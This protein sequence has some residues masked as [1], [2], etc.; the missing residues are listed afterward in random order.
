MAQEEFCADGS[1]RKI[2]AL[3]RTI[4]QP[5]LQGID[6]LSDRQGGP[7]RGCEQ[8]DEHGILAGFCLL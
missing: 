3:L 4:A 8:G 1:E 5:F 2:L 7:I 6:A